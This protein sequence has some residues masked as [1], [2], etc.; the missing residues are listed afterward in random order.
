MNYVTGYTG[1]SGDVSKQS[2]HYLALHTE[3]NA[4]TVTVEIVGGTGAVELDSDGISIGYI[5][6]NTAVK[7]V[8]TLG[9]ETLTKQFALNLTL[10]EE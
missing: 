2:G 1:F 4:D 10:A 3:S 7:F 6:E 8:A 9:D 5:S